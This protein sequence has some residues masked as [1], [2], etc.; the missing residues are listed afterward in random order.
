MKSLLTSKSDR[1]NRRNRFLLSNFPSKI[2]WI[3]TM[4]KIWSTARLWSNLELIKMRGYSMGVAFPQFLNFLKCP[5]RHSRIPT[6]RPLTLE[7]ILIP[8]RI[9]KICTSTTFRNY[10]IFS[11]TK[12]CTELETIFWT[13]FDQMVG[14]QNQISLL[15]TVLYILSCSDSSSL[16][17]FQRINYS[18]II[19]TY[20]F[21]RKLG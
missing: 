6:Q 18:K 21:V 20:V 3:W 9:C 13:F 12:F 4:L 19:Q 2:F 15:Y 17:I 16:Y 8:S 5:L 1:W 10:L 11:T 14:F 7:C